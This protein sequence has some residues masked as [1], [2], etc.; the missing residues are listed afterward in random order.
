MDPN[1]AIISGVIALSPSELIESNDHFSVPGTIANAE[2]DW[3]AGS[4]LTSKE[5][6]WPSPEFRIVIV[7]LS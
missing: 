4:M 1:E 6:I 3:D 5:V 7:G 2:R